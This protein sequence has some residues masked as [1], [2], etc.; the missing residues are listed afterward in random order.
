MK[1]HFITSIIALCLFVSLFSCKN[2]NQAN[3]EEDEATESLVHITKEQFNHVNMQTGSLQEVEFNEEIKARGTTDVPPQS[4]ATVSPVVSGSV[5]DIFVRPGDQVKKGQA[6]LSFEGPEII[7]LQQNYLEISEQLK[8]LESEYMRQK[9]LF[10]EIFLLKNYFLKQKVIT[11][12][13]K[14][15]VKD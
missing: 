11:G 12:K 10:A 13:Q 7:G 3:D 14:P 5:K 6:L 15:L 2:R 1:H 4:K 9:T 8:S